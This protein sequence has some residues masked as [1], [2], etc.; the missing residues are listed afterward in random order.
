M[1]FDFR[2][3]NIVFGTLKT[4]HAVEELHEGKGFMLVC[5]LHNSVG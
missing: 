4:V 5:A 2:I 1:V 3:A